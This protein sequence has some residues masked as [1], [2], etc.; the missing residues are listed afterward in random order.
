MGEECGEEEKTPH[1]Q[2]F[3]TLKKKMRFTALKKL[4]PNSH[5][6]KRF[7][8]REQA[9]QYCKKEKIL[10]EIGTLSQ[11]TS[12][13]K[14]ERFLEML[15][16][17]KTNM[18]IIDEEPT[19]FFHISKLNQWRMEFRKKEAKKWRDIKVYVLWGDTGVGKTRE[20]VANCPDAFFIHAAQLAHGWW[21]GYEG[22]KEIIIDEFY[23]QISIDQMLRY[24]D[25]YACRLNMKGSH[26]WAMWETVVITSNF[27]PNTW[28]FNAPEK[29]REALK[30]RITDVTELIK[31]N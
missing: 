11:D 16:E 30:R 24:L 29:S 5:L 28:Y 10:H 20:A 14:S 13:K 31:E 17:G 19:A 6:E 18:E 15:Q 21:D 4:L 12:K 9:A 3:F 23:D 26:T 2:V 25:G 7:G 8:T 27:E 22:E 1:Y